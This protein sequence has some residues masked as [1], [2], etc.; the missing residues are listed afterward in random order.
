M[1]DTGLSEGAME[2]KGRHAL[3]EKVPG[4][5]CPVEVVATFAFT[6]NVEVL[7]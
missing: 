4:E 2:P 1:M 6:Y 5:S 3:S 7:R